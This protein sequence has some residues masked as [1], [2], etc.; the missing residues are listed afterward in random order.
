ME[1]PSGGVERMSTTPGTRGG[2][3]RPLAQI[4]AQSEKGSAWWLVADSV[5]TL[6]GGAVATVVRG[7]GSW[8]R[9][10]GVRHGSRLGLGDG[11][12][13]GIAFGGWSGPT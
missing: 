9:G 7:S 12:R 3:R 4:Q 6:H 11:L 10:G 13:L 1:A 5:P 8:G 2:M